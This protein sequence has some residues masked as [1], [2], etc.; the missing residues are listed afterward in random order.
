MVNRHLPRPALRLTAAATLA[1][2]AAGCGGSDP[3]EA[4]VKPAYLGTVTRVDYDGVSDDLLTA[5]L[6]RAGLAGAAPAVSSPPTA[7]ELRRLAIHTNYRAV[8]DISANGGYGTLYGPNITADGVVTSGDGK[9]AGSEWIAYDDDGTGQRNVTLM[10]QI[11]ST[12]DVARPCIV[13]GTSSGS[14]G[15]Y[16][17]IGSSGE[18]GLKRGCA[19][20]YADKGSGNGVHDLQADTVNLI[21]GT[22]TTAP[23]AG[24]A[25]N[26]TA[27]AGAALASFNATTPNRFAVKHAHSKQNPEKDWGLDTLH[28]VEFAF[29]ALNQRYGAPLANGL[30]RADFKPSNTIVIASSISNGAGAA[31]AA[32]E[33][34]GAGLIDGVAVTEPNVQPAD[35]TT[36]T[37]QRGSL[38]Y[39]G[40]ARPLYDYFSYANLL[41][42]CAALATDVAASPFAYTGGT[43]FAA[44]ARCAALAANGLVSGATTADQ[45]AD[46]LARL[47]AYGWEPEADLLH[48]SHYLFATPAIVMTYANSYG[49][50]GVD[51]RLCSYS[52]AAVDGSGVP[53]TSPASIA[54][55]FGTGNGVP[56]SA[57]LQ[58]V[59]DAAANGPHT[60]ATA[61]SPSTGQFD[62][63]YDGAACQ[64][65]LWAGTSVNAARV[66]SG[67]AQVRRSANLRGKPTL[68]VH[69]RSDTLIPVNFTSRPYAVRNQQR[70]GSASGLRYIEVTNAQHFDSFLGFAGYDTRFIPLHVYFNRALDA[71]WAHLTTGAALPPSQVVRTTPRGGTPGAAPAIQASQL[72]AFSASPGADAITVTTSA[73][74]IPD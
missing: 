62:F 32:A 7:A 47:R 35:G 61:T 5:G 48:A 33:L 11:P 46:A 34:D 12:F 74:T 57:G 53:T 67:I 1:A 52:Y 3:I 28:A 58:I 64:R 54:S 19:V 49:R 73:I 42:P 30:R 17:A 41:Q 25:S 70:E 65:E 69:G 37:V 66:Q 4:S 50:F 39:T 44:T 56:P 6:G 43:A 2:L 29:W 68:I 45:A 14:R 16:G 40:G 27:L 22:R 8:L 10:V 26:F 13:T 36:I 59:Y 63:A 20:A 18:W 24:S 72:P 9:I 71:M 55:V 51:E 60:Y 31:I 23:A 15:V 38:T 21:D